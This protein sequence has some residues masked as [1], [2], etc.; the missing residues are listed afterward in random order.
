[1]KIKKETSTT[2][3]IKEISSL[4][5]VITTIFILIGILQIALLSR[6]WIGIIFILL[7]LIP[8]ILAKGKEIV[9]DKKA[10]KIGIYIRG[11]VYTKKQE[12]AVKD[13]KAI[14]FEDTYKGKD[15]L[16][17]TKSFIILKKKKRVLL[18]I[19]SRS[20]LSIRK[21]K[22]DNAIPKKIAKILD[23]RYREIKIEKLPQ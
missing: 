8:I 17:Y 5:Y 3:V 14:E 6:L 12:Y 11:L 23:V 1:M 21:R 9:V 10:R 19:N 7:S 2:L 22:A 15:R 13:I 4:P 18:S 20:L 16:L